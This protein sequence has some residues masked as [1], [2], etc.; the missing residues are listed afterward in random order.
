MMGC[1]NSLKKAFIDA[2]KTYS[3]KKR[4]NA[5]NETIGDTEVDKFAEV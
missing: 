4:N 2:L 1:T 3:V 5:R